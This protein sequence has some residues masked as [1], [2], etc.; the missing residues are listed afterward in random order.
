[1]SL[2]PLT[3]LAAALVSLT[4]AALPLRAGPMDDLVRID[5]LDGGLTDRGTYQ[6]A[7]R[8]TLSDGWKTYW[9]APGEA[10]IPP[11]F[12]WRGS[13]NLG[14]VQITWP[15]PHL[16]DQGGVQT[17]GYTR[18]MVLP[19]EITPKT[20][21]KPVR[22]KGELDFGLCKDVCIP[23]SLDFNHALDAQAGRN[24]TIAAALA[25]RPFSAR[26]AGVKA[27]IC[28]LSPTANGLRVEAHITMP[29]AGGAEVAVFETGDPAIWT[30][31]PQVTRRGDTLIAAT[32][33]THASGRAAYA[34]DRS[35]LRITVLGRDHAV[36]IHGCTAG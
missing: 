25:Q 29:S 12:S 34:L 7:I 18:Q 30:G 14:A 21:G 20:P 32:E 23:G 19:I 16:F 1:M 8:L 33:L 22:L 4:L 35:Q 28:R 5:V 6:A 11:A 31:T 2:N 9:R 26:E 10:G 24:P 13:R 27:S 15:T 36:D 17:I 3:Y